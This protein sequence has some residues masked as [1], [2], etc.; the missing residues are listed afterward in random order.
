[1]K[2]D[3]ILVI[4]AGGYIG[5]QLLVKLSKIYGT[6]NVVATDIRKF[7]Y[8]GIFEILDIL[9]CMSSAKFELLGFGTRRVLLLS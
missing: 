4:G 8:D 2:K 6:D 5:S 1:M 3:K 9:H 7:D